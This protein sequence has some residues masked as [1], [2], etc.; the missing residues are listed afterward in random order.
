MIRIR[1]II[2]YK[3]RQSDYVYFEN[4]WMMK[5]ENNRMVEQWKN[6]VQKYWEDI[7]GYEL[8]VYVTK[9]EMPEKHIDMVK[10]LKYTAFIMDQPLSMVQSKSRKRAYVDVRKVAA[11]ILF[12]EDYDPMDIERGL[13]FPNR[14]AY[15]YIKCIQNQMD[16]ERGYKATYESIRDKVMYL[17]K[18]I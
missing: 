4:F 6:Q 10:V 3:Q 17:T 15:H 1:S 7:K 16:S 14:I 5:L 13:D 9:D 11:K 8:R 18:V 2:V 12:D